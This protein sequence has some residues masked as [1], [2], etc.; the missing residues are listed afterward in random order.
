VYTVDSRT[1]KAEAFSVKAG[2][3][4]A[5]GSNSDIRAFIGKGTQTFDPWG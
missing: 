1:P 5:V 4:A 3:F 2:R